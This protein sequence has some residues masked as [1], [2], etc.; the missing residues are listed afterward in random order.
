[1]DPAGLLEICREAVYVLIKLSMPILLIALAVGLLVSLFQALTQIQENTL[2]FVPKILAVFVALL[3]LTP[4]MV[5]TLKVFNEQIN[6][7]IINIE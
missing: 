2:S 3:F 1:M 6:S 4:Y 7:L 5:N